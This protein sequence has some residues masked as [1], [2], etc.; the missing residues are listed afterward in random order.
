MENMFCYQ[1]EQTA[2]GIGCTVS[3]VCG[4]KPVVAHEQ[5]IMTCEMIAL[6]KAVQKEGHSSTS[7]VDL[8]VDGLFTTITNVNFDDIKNC[9]SNR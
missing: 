8:I 3:G 5:D 7:A 9:Q 4:K 2:K 6:A 1:C